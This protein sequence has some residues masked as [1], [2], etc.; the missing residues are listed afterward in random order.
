MKA[1]SITQPYAELI[2]NGTKLIE[3]RSWKT[4]YRGKILI[5]AS[6]TK[7][8]KEYKNNLELMDLVY[9]KTLDY[10]CV[11]CECDLVDCIEMTEEFI[12]NLK[13]TNHKEYI[14]GF[15]SVGRY[16]WILENVR[17]INPEKAKGHLGLW[18]F[19]MTT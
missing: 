11:I 4:N 1:L 7:I 2:K 15:Y 16:A 17:I 9:G 12:D 10:G 19:K 5:H 3:T 6:A 14:S 18:E 8:P 13:R